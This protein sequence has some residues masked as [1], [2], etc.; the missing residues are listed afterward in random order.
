[1]GST[2]CLDRMARITL[3]TPGRV[4][5]FHAC[6]WAGLW[7]A[8]VIALTLAKTEGLSL[9]VMSAILASAIAVFLGLVVAGKA[10]TG[11]ERI[12]YYHHQIGVLAASALVARAF[13]QPALPYLDVAVLAIGAF[14]A[15][16]RIG[17]LMVGC[18]HGRPFRWGIRYRDEH[19]AAGFPAH[20]VGVRLF[21]VQ[22][23]ES[24]G[25]LLIVIVG[26]IFV[27]ERRLP[28]AALLWY[29]FTY[30]ALR[31]ALEF[32]RGDSAR[33]YTWG[34]SQPQW[35]SLWLI[36]GALGMELAGRAALTA[37]HVA[38][39]LGVI[40]VMAAVTLHRKLD[41]SQRFGFFHPRHVSEI[42]E[43]LRVAGIA[44]QPDTLA[45]VSTSLG[46]R[47]ST[48]QIRIP[49][50]V[51]RQYAFSRLNG[52]MQRETAAQLASLVIEL[53]HRSASSELLAGNRGVFHLLVREGKR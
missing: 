49:E 5:A 32:V 46:L 38:L 18:C 16:G 34:F 42:A 20:L 12:V 4:S 25:V 23:L 47:I 28:G 45:I 51:I 17:C 21:P 8:V 13:H 19:A 15:C 43:A 50:A 36:S 52:G 26:V 39:V 30:G 40:A 41:R 14:L 11:R 9:R 44:G 37:W 1:M 22:A 48:E 29:T 27:L 35:L 10:I 6:G 33:P 7:S 24:F 53:R 2:T 3:R 31:F